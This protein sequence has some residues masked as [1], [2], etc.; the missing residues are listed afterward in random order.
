VNGT[1]ESSAR[2]A[3]PT[4]VIRPGGYPPSPPVGTARLE[5]ASSGTQSRRATR[6][7]YVPV[8]VARFERATL[9][10]PARCSTKLSHTPLLFVLSRPAVHQIPYVPPV[11]SEI[12]RDD[13]LGFPG[14]YP[15]PDL[16]N[17]FGSQDTMPVL[18][19]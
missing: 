3:A 13:R 1:R 5:L 10:P 6:L 19:S 17:L 9:A 14:H 8:G 18:F 12:T 16:P 11:Y 15:S 7:R 2:A 4:A